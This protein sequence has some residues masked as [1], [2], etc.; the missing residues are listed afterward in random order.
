MRAGCGVTH[1]T[2]R[3]VAFE[4][5]QSR[6]CPTA[7][8]RLAAREASRRGAAMTDS[9][10][11][12]S[13]NLFFILHSD[14]TLSMR[15]YDFVPRIRGTKSWLVMSPTKPQRSARALCT[16]QLSLRSTVHCASANHERSCEAPTESV[17]FR[18]D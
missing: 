11:P 1:R 7:K 16:S 15:G 14:T 2:P 4:R 5:S 3:N 17:C 13:L 6:E 8:P 9:L 10:N 12:N 18:N